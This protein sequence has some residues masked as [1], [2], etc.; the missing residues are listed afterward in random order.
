VR[1]DA[2]ADFALKADAFAAALPQ[3]VTE[4][5]ASAAFV[6]QRA[7]DA[8]AS[9]QAAAASEAAAEADRA[10]VAANTATVASNTATVVARADEVAANTL[11]VASNTAQ[12]ATDKQ[13]VADALASIAGGPV[14]SV[15][16]MTG[17]VT[18][19]ATQAGAETLT[20]KT[21]ADPIVAL[22]G[23]QGEAGQ[24]PVSQ[25]AG[26]P[27]VWGGV[28]P[29]YLHVRDQKAAGS[30]GGTSVTGLQTRVLNTVVT[31]TIPGASLASNLV[32]LPAGVY[33][34]SAVAPSITRS[35]R[36]SLYNVTSAGIAVLGTAAGST[37]GSTPISA[38]ISLIHGRFTLLAESQVKINHFIEVGIT[39][40]GLGDR[41]SDGNPCVFTDVMILKEA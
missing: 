17:A 12:V 35:H 11:Q 23:S 30:V 14:Y 20:N 38:T 39:D 15:N 4:T 9:A 22:G 3:F 29:G 24:V 33:R 37:D 18:G 25:G 26:L 27:P 28:S 32:T 8:D 41:V 19:I 2:P 7:I 40:R 5:N 10:E 13:A 1:S 6:D 31:N 36:A 34:V 21:L 16:G